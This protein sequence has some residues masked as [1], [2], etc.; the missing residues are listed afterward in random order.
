MLRVGIA[1]LDITLG[2]REANR[3]KVTQWMERH[4]AEKAVES[5]V[6][7]LPEIWDVGYALEDA[8]TLAD[9]EGSG[10]AVFLG[11]LAR[12]YGVWFAGGSVLAGTTKGAVN[13]AQVVDPRGLLVATYD[14]AHLIPL[15]DEPRYLRAGSA[16]CLFDLEGITA[17]CVICYDIRF[18]EW[19]RRYALQ[20]AQ[21]LF[22]S[23]EWPK[24]RIDHWKAL[25]RARAIENMMYVV[26]CN[27][28]GTSKETLFGGTSLVFDPWGKTLHEGGEEEEG[29]FVTIDPSTVEGIR[30]HL[31]VFRMRRPELYGN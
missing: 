28:V 12:R 23:A 27:R 24:I 17:G 1:Q 4:C 6:I 25:L 5:T 21:V 14:K 11:D 9:P 2:N 16:E 20:G 3:R 30:D 15:M 10:A 31:Q 8:E 13:R 29:A 7:V 18:C 19:T 26:A 22:V